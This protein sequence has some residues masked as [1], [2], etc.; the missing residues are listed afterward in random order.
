MQVEVAE[1]EAIGYTNTWQVTLQRGDE[2]VSCAGV[3][4]Y[5]EEDEEVLGYL[6]DEWAGYAAA[7]DVNHTHWQE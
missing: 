4:D 2:Y 6:F 1:V 5:V 7:G 3:R